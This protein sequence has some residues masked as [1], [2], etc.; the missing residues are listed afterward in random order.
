MTGR[1][2]FHT[3]RNELIPVAS[4]PDV[5]VALAERLVAPRID[6]PWFNHRA[7]RFLNGRIIIPGTRILGPSGS[8]ARHAGT[9]PI[10]RR[11]VTRRAVQRSAT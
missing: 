10:R 11:S 6:R 7:I 3:D 2:R 5:L 1:S 8:P 4:W 9:R